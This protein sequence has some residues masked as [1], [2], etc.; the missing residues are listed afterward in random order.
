MALKS[1]PPATIQQQNLSKNHDHESRILYDVWVH[2]FDSH[3][4]QKEAREE[5]PT[6]SSHNPPVSSNGTT[7]SHFLPLLLC[8]VLVTRCKTLI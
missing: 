2:R 1:T 5:E 4:E 6:L 3:V 8:I 7:F